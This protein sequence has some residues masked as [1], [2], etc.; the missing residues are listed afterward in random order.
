MHFSETG[1]KVT[2]TTV[3]S[4]L[5]KLLDEHSIP[6]EVHPSD[7]PIKLIVE[8]KH[9]PFEDYTDCI[10]SDGEWSNG[11]GHQRRRDKSLRLVFS[12]SF[13]VVIRNYSNGTAHIVRIVVRR[14]YDKR[15]LTQIVEN[16][17]NR[18][19]YH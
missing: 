7:G 13:A 17:V 19:T 8:Q 11:K 3:D 15:K 14:R 18:P 9:T 2:A 4:R 1:G 16:I 10:A 12:G 5:R 6:L